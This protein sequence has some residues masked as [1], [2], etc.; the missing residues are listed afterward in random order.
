MLIQ[1]WLGVKNCE[2]T[3]HQ[4]FLT[5]A[6]S[7]ARPKKFAGGPR[8]FAGE[9]RF[10]KN[11]GEIFDSSDLA[12][13]RGNV[14]VSV[15]KNHIPLLVAETRRRSDRVGKK[16]RGCR[17]TLESSKRG[18]PV[19]ECSSRHFKVLYGEYSLPRKISACVTSWGPLS[20]DGYIKVSVPKARTLFGD[21]N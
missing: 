9:V 8:D 6:G 3:P 4:D 19:P 10:A 18:S 20:T 16:S 15:R 12:A 14:R 7:R 17:K 11:F 21:K 13:E 2:N 5:P 1:I